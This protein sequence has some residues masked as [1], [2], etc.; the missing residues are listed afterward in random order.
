MAAHDKLK[1]SIGFAEIFVYPNRIKIEV[2]E[3]KGSHRS[4]I[5]T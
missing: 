1:K 2:S 5:P 3:L 4:H